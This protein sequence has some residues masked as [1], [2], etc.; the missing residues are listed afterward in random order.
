VFETYFAKQTQNINYFL[1][2]SFRQFNDQPD[3]KAYLEDHYPI[4][5]QGTGYLIYDLTSPKN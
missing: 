4:L 1:I 2:T 5:A 3:L